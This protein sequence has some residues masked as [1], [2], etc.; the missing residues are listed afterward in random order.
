MLSQHTRGKYW[1]W[2]AICSFSTRVYLPISR[3]DSDSQLSSK[4]RMLL[5]DQKDPVIQ[6]L[7]L[8]GHL[9][10][11]MSTRNAL[12]SLLSLC[13]FFCAYWGGYACPH[14]LW[15]SICRDSQV[16]FIE[17]LPDYSVLHFKYV[18]W[19]INTKVYLKLKKSELSQPF[20]IDM[21]SVSTYRWSSKCSE[22]DSK[23]P[24]GPLMGH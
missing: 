6:M 23:D 10:W 2:S 9:A 17:T 5:M 15:P 3:C 20:Q 18:P 14:G 11:K 8:L 7:S 16:L 12:L 4:Q 22:T 24:V 19:T 1:N 21:Q 13:P